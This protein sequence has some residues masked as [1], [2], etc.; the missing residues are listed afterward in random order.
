[1]AAAY[2][3]STPANLRPSNP[4]HFL[5]W[6][7]AVANNRIQKLGKNFVNNV[8]R[9]HSKMERAMP[10]FHSGQEPSTAPPHNCSDQVENDLSEPN[11]D[12][13]FSNQ[14]H[15]SCRVSKVHKIPLTSAAQ[16][17][18]EKAAAECKTGNYLSSVAAAGGGEGVNCS[19]VDRGEGDAN[20]ERYSGFTLSTQCYR[21]QGT[22][23]ISNGDSNMSSSVVT[24]IP[25]GYASGNGGGGGGLMNSS[26]QLNNRRGGELANGITTT[27]TGPGF[28]HQIQSARIV[29]SHPFKHQQQ[30]VVSSASTSS[31]TSSVRSS[32]PKS[33]VQ[34][35]HYK[36][37]PNPTITAEALKAM[38]I[39][40]PTELNSCRSKY[41]D[42]PQPIKCV[43]VEVETMT[44][45]DI[46]NMLELRTLHHENQ[47][48]YNLSC[49]SS[50]TSNSN[51]ASM[52]D[53]SSSPLRNPQLPISSP[54]W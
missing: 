17:N 19:K 5:T 50:G 4:R 48:K 53:S 7:A 1:M 24:G 32:T 38:I 41:D 28:P 39:N 43:D 29:Q 33:L 45:S 37:P 12:R 14:I 44:S 40:S 36:I 8:S 15:D 23:I 9:L 6:S 21:A 10:A 27:T 42:K 20:E 3:G 31:S 51:N 26:S 46:K 49:S 54:Q 11:K 13:H 18:R 34:S 22:E 35:G 16:N 30:D 2:A 52:S 47:S 25:L